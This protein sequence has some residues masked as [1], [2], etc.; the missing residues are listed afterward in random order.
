MDMNSSTRT[1]KIMGDYNNNALFLTYLVISDM[2]Y[3][4]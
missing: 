3:E 1:N 4:V 2:V